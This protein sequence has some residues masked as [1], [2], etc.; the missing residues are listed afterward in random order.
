MN[1]SD[2]FYNENVL[3]L[4]PVKKLKKLIYGSLIFLQK[5]GILTGVC[6]FCIVLRHYTS[7]VFKC[8]ADRQ[9]VNAGPQFHLIFLT[10]MTSCMSS[11]FH[12]SALQTVQLKQRQVTVSPYV[13]LPSLLLCPHQARTKTLPTPGVSH[14]QKQE[15]VKDRSAYNGK[16]DGFMRER[17][18]QHVCSKNHKP[19]GYKIGSGFKESRRIQSKDEKIVRGRKMCKKKNCTSLTKNRLLF[20]PWS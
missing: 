9:S 5:L 3:L 16:S 7:Y 8:I 17:I 13:D 12:K 1:K 18:Q 14:P 4:C 10:R 6:T 19:G 2:Y 20:T 15:E 11:G